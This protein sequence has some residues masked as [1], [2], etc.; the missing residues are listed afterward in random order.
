MVLPEYISYI[1][2]EAPTSSA[3]YFSMATPWGEK[4]AFTVTN[5]STVFLTAT[6]NADETELTLSVN[7]A[8]TSLYDTT[9]EATLTIT[10]TVTSESWVSTL[11]IRFY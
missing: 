1:I 6:I 10:S 9:Q 11:Q 7:S 3:H 2:G 4:C 5:D 8:D